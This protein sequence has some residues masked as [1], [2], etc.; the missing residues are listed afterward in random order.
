[1]NWEVDVFDCDIGGVDFGDIDE[2]WLLVKCGV[3][4]R[5]VECF[6]FQ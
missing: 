6:V 1:M 5:C 2:G 4:W 3:G